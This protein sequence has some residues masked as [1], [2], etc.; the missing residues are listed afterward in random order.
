MNTYDMLMIFPVTKTEDEYDKLLETVTGE[1]TR[2]GGNVVRTDRMG[3]RP[4]ARQLG[5]A[6]DGLYAR[7]WIKL[8]PTHVDAL[9]ARFHLIEDI[10]R[11]QIRRI[12]GEVPPPAPPKPLV[13]ARADAGAME[14][15]R[16]G[17]P[18]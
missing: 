10:F 11:F 17:E 16:Y 8:P 12:E 7:L 15:A 18:Q 14:G 2:A 1:V 13:D 3:R 6:A 9:Q 5:K 4:F